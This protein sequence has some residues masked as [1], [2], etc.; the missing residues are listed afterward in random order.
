LT[1]N[2]QLPDYSTIK[3]RQ[4]QMWASGDFNV[5]GSRALLISELL[6]EAVDIRAGQ[7]IL[8]V[9]T[10]NGNAALAAARRF[11][12]TTG[13]DYVPSLLDYAR[14][15]AKA[16]GL[17]AT[18]QEGDA[19]NLPFPDASFDVVLS[20]LGAMFAPN[21]QQTAHELLR[22]CRPGG[23]IG[24]ANWTPDGFLGQLFQVTSRYIPPPPDV[25]PAMLWGNEEHVR[26]LFA[27]GIT[28]LQATKRSFIFRYQSAEHYVNFTRSNYG[29]SLK[30]FQALDPA[31]QENLARDQAELV[32]RFNRS[33]DGTMVWPADY[34]EIVATKC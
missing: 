15:R 20:V 7:K 21:Q 8:D 30:A 22:V 24:M 1:T 2:N 25:K 34:L 16:D 27:D 10:G 11:A 19:E 12:E 28:S 5:V 23:K 13:V 6:C 4:Q 32:R 14:I 29:P 9:A 3:Q 26:N 33:D 31:Q 17:T 18:F